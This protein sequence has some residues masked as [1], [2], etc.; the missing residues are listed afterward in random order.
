GQL[1]FYQDWESVAAL[2]QKH[3]READAGFVTSYCPDGISASELLVSSPARLRIFYDMD[4]PVTL[5]RLEAGEA[6]PYLPLQGLGDFDVVLS[7]TG[8]AALAELKSRLGAKNVIP[9]YGSV[10]P[11]AHHPAPASA[12]YQSD[13]SYLGTYAADRQ[14]TLQTLFIEPARRS[15]QLRFVL[16]GSLYPED[17]F[18]PG[19]VKCFS[20]VPPPEHS[21]FYCSSRL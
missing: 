18:L 13:L 11:D 8:G 20:H 19:N 3:L 1:C 17:C 5:A 10:D 12:I 7:Y 14:E 15:P 21:S 9:L 6:V 4:T 2:A 16:G